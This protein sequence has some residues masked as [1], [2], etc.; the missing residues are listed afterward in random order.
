MKGSRLVEPFRHPFGGWL[1]LLLCVGLAGCESE[2]TIPT[3]DN[4]Q[5]IAIPCVGVTGKG[6]LPGIDYDLSARNLA[7]GILGF[8]MIAPPVIVLVGETYCPIGDT[9][10]VR[11]R[12]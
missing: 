5:G 12:P 2:R 1:A 7:L 8:E 4:P 10:I 11:G 9:T 3:R 6:N